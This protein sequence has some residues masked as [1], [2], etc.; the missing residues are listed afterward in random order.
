[1]SKN[2]NSHIQMPKSILRKFEEYTDLYFECSSIL[3]ET[4]FT[5]GMK[6]GI[7][8]LLDALTNN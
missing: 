3:Q 4:A 7:K 5:Y 8:I 1:M 6:L 2:I